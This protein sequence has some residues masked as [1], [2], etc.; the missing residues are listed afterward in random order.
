MKFV[1][2][3]WVKATPQQTVRG[4]ESAHMPP[5]ALYGGPGGYVM[6]GT[7]A[8]L[9]LQYMDDEGM[10]MKSKNIIEEAKSANGWCKLS[11]SRVYELKNHLREIEN[12]EL[13]DL[14]EILKI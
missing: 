14:P 2:L 5:N 1:G 12:F 11:V 10:N 6:P 8:K 9:V 3:S 13:Q 7:S 4:P